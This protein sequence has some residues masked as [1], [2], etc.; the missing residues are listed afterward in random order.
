MQHIYSDGGDFIKLPRSIVKYLLKLATVCPLLRVTRLTWNWYLASG[1]EP[2]CSGIWSE[3][4]G[5]WEELVDRDGGAGPHWGMETVLLLK[6]CSICSPLVCRNKRALPGLAFCC[7]L[8]G[9]KLPQPACA[10]QSLRFL[11]QGRGRGAFCPLLPLQHV[12]AL[13][14]RMCSEKF[15]IKDCSFPLSKCLNVHCSSLRSV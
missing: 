6:G 1:V 15:R 2:V 10:T 4:R 14:A 9:A 3:E 8:R 5:F 12:C 11:A 13:A 7:S